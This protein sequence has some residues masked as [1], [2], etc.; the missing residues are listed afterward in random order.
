MTRSTHI[1]DEE[2]VL[3]RSMPRLLIDPAVGGYF[4]GKIASSIGI[5]IHNVVAAVVVFQATGSA[6]MVGAVSIAQFMPQVL[7]APLMGAVADRADR[8]RLVVIGR[9]VAAV[10]SWALAGWLFVGGSEAIGNGLPVIASAFVVGMGFAASIPAMQAIV[11][12]LARPSELPTVIAITSTPLTIARATGPAI[13]ALLL[14]TVGPAWSFFAAGTFQFVFA[15]VVSVL[16][17]RP[18]ER[19]ESKDSSVLGGLRY[20]RV[21]VSMA[22]LLLAVA[23]VGFGVDPVITLTPPIAEGFGSD[24]ELVAIMASAF[25]AGAAF[26]VFALGVVRRRVGTPRFGTGGLALLGGSLVAVA[27][28]PAPAFAV[29]SFFV[30]GI[31]M[32]AAITSLSTQIQQRVPEDLRGRIM[33]LWAVCFV[34]SRPIAAAFNGG[35]ADLWSPR[36]ALLVLAIVLFVTAYLTRPTRV[37]A[38]SLVAEPAGA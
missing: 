24:P 23:G 26:C 27:V 31:G 32:M 3:P 30:G 22:L 37:A 10:G 21:D 17:L 18:V 2:G 1:E 29:A 28:S 5:W 14:L 13:G 6:F 19:P 9:A 8:R 35:V 16:P 25:G 4:Y 7:L 11:P 34:G 36:A 15:T 38:R 20:L 33:A 12:A